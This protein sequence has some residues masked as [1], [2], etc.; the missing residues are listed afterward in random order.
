MA[1]TDWTSW[2][3]QKIL[4]VFLGAGICTYANFL[5]IQNN[6]DLIQQLS[7]VLGMQ[8]QQLLCFNFFYISLIKKK[9]KEKYR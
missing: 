9:E 1:G 4:M 8:T 3:K 7:S 2:Y 5:L 6:N